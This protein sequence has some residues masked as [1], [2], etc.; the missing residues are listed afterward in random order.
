MGVLSLSDDLPV[1]GGNGRVIYSLILFSLRFVG[2][3]P[4]LLALKQSFD[5]EYN[6]ADLEPFDKV[7]LI[8]FHQAV[9]AYAR[10]RLWKQDG[11]GDCEAL[12]DDLLRL[13]SARLQHLNRH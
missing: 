7:Q 9:S 1:W 10:Y 3:K 2:E 11:V 4:H 5:H 6:S 13:I 12:M 8:E